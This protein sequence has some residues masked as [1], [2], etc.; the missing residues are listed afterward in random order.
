MHYCKQCRSYFTIGTEAEDTRFGDQNAFVVCLTRE[1]CP[2]CRQKAYD[3]AWKEKKS[4]RWQYV[5]V[6]DI[7]T[8]IIESL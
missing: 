3:E 2:N 7:A 5:L 4:G 6:Q 1:I 8:G